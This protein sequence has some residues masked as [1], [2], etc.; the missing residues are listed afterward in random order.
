MKQFVILGA[1]LVSLSLV[2]CNTMHG[3][4]QD[5]ERGGQKMESGASSVQH[6]TSS[7]DTSRR[8][9]NA[10]PTGTTAPEPSSDLTTPPAGR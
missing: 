2:G 4:G 9:P 5:V 6:G 10:P 3:M 1:T 8:S 7:S